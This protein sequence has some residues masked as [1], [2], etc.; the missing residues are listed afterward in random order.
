M[1]KGTPCGGA[2]RLTRCFGI[3]HPK[4]GVSC[5][6]V[7]EGVGRGLFV[8]SPLLRVSPWRFFSI[9]FLCAYAIKEKRVWMLAM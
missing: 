9:A 4:F 2:N 6:K 1:K 7:F 3:T 5:V 8:K